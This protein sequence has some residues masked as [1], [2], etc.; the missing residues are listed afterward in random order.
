MPFRINDVVLSVDPVKMY[1][2]INYGKDIVCVRYPEV[3]RFADYTEFYNGS[4]EY[5]HAISAVIRRSKRKYSDTQRFEILSKSSWSSRTEQ[6]L[7]ALGE[8]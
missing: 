1:E 8:L 4:E 5:C 6:I 7:E 2:Y 3:Q